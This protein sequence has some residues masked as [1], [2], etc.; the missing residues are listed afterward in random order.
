M[1]SYERRHQALAPPAVFYRRILR[2]GVVGF[3]LVL[4][5]LLVGMAG[6]AGFEGLGFLDSFLNS[7]MILAGMGPLHNPLTPGGKLFAGLFALYS[8]FA[9]LGIAAVV[10]APILHRLMHRFHLEEDAEQG[11]PGKHGGKRDR[12]G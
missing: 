4:A 11:K 7:A 5:S 9:V 10:F 2:T 8:G 12:K 3:V 1:F 6:Y